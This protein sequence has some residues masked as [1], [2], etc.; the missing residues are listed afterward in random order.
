MQR[1]DFLWRLS[2]QACTL[3][4][5]GVAMFSTD[6]LLVFT[7]NTWIRLLEQEHEDSR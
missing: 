6:T 7:C 1:R 4:V 3:L 5:R 2:A